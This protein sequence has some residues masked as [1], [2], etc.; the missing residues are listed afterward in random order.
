MKKIVVILITLAMVFSLTACGK[1]EKDTTRSSE[2]IPRYTVY[3]RWS[4]G[5]EEL[6][7]YKIIYHDEFASLCFDDYELDASYVNLI[8][9]EN[10]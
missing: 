1:A 4:D 8:I 10:K 3:L 2:D 9:Y 7:P 5:E 6:H